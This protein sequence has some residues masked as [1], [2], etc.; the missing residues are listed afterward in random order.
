MSQGPQRTEVT[1]KDSGCPCRGIVSTGMYMSGFPGGQRE[2]LRGQ[3][4]EGRTASSLH[5]D[6]GLVRLRDR[7]LA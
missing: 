3:T 2:I 4:S 7:M 6:H 5:G 1:E